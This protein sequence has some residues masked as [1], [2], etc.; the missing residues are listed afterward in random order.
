MRLPSSSRS[1]SCFSSQDQHG[2]MPPDGGIF[3]MR[4]AVVSK[5]KGLQGTEEGN[6]CSA[7]VSNHLESARRLC[8]NGRYNKQAREKTPRL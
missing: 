1:T 7:N 8:A 5:H 6:L 3:G 2:G 4:L